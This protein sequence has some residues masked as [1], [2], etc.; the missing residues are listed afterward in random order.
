L[1]K[2]LPLLTVSVERSVRVNFAA[3]A[4][5]YLL[6]I[7]GGGLWGIGAVY[8][9]FA[10]EIA[11]KASG[12]GPVAAVFFPLF[13]APWALFASRTSMKLLSD[14]LDLLAPGHQFQN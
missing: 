8:T 6:V 4:L 5:I 3:T 12:E 9:Y 2:R 14:W 7:A 13:M 10:I 1:K 11:L